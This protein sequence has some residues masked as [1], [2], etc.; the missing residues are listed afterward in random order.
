[1]NISHRLMQR[2]HSNCFE[3]NRQTR[4]GTR[5]SLSVLQ[6]RERSLLFSLSCLSNIFLV[7]IL[8]SPVL[9]S[10]LLRPCPFAQHRSF[11]ISS[12]PFQSDDNENIDYTLTEKTTCSWITQFKEASFD[13][14]FSHS[15]TTIHAS[16]TH[17]IHASVVSRDDHH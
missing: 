2:L 17:S 3:K 12:L 1:M 16:L 4:N 13:N 7:F 10:S 5:R 11:L 6:L 14:I 8:F 9:S 15:T